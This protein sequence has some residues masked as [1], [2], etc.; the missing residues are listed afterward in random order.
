MK[1]RKIVIQPDL[2]SNQAQGNILRKWLSN[3]G[4]FSVIMGGTKTSKYLSDPDLLIDI[5]EF[6]P[7]TKLTIIKKNFSN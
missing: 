7:I 3:Q 5:T 6:L 1:R 4:E 2:F